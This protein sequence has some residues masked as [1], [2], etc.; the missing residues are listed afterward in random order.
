MVH[1]IVELA[2]RDALQEA[3]EG[4]VQ[5]EE[6]FS[7]A[8][9]DLDNFLAVNEDFGH[10]VGDRVLA[11][12]ARLAGEAARAG[13][14]TAYRVSGDEFAVVLPGVPI[15]GA[16]LRMERLREAVEFA[17]GEF[18]LPDGRGVTVT[19]GVAQFPRDGKDTQSVTTAADIALSSAKD[20][21]RNAVRLPTNEEMVLKS[22]Y[23][24]ATDARRLK[25]LAGKLNRK[26][27]LLLREAL[28]D[29]I[30]KYDR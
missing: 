10:A 5:S 6:A 2:G 21:G 28:S 30:K 3:M 20:G 14:G 15:E 19:I 12:V 29:L 9:L 16:F 26:E 13:G 4:L 7:L 18:A 25:T 27:S 11:T 1:Q 24:P 23:Y 17:T 22:C 8:L